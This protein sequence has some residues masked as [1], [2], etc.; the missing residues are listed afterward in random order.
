MEIRK[1]KIEDVKGIIGII[2]DA[3][4]DMESEGIYQ[5]D[6]IYPNEDV[7]TGDIYKENLYVYIDE[8]IIKGFIT[9]N[10]FQDREYESIKWKYDTGRHLIIHRLCISPKYKGKGIATTFI[11]YAE[12][13][14]KENKYE[15]IRL[16]SFTQNNH[17]CK[18]Y[19]KNGYEK[20]GIV[21]FRKGEFLCF[22]KKL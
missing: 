5:W 3:I 17:A 9:L 22:E 11:K 19:E 21:T 10:E 20:R 16:D 2:K 1:G 13:L 7:I 18:L 12:R 8:N 4:I 6:N 15:S 14:G